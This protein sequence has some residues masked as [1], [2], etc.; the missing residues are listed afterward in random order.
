MPVFC[1]SMGAVGTARAPAPA[2][3]TAGRAAPAPA[4]PAAAPALREEGA[5]GAA[6]QPPGELFLPTPED[7]SGARQRT[8]CAGFGCA[9]L[10]WGLPLIVFPLQALLGEEVTPEDWGGVALCLLLVLAFTL[11]CRF[12]GPKALQ[13]GSEQASQ[14]A[15]R[16]V[17]LES[18]EELRAACPATLRP[19][20][21]EHQAGTLVV[22]TRRLAF[23]S[24]PGVKRRRLGRDPA[25][26]RGRRG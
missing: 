19:E 7:L 15:L 25:H 9:M 5:E 14:E 21:E 11:W 10:I 18:G 17:S 24:E 3:C 8:T 20:G 1:P 6:P 4:A 22:T 26:A 2:A 23:V 16:W 13:E 12:A